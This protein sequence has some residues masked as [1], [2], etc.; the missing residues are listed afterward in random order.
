[1]AAP[2]LTDPPACTLPILIALAPVPPHFIVCHN[3]G[4]RTKIYIVRSKGVRTYIDI[5]GAGIYDNTRCP[6]AITY[7]YCFSVGIRANI[8]RTG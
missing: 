2:I 3:C 4:T 8:Y 7:R 1:M 6:S 5:A